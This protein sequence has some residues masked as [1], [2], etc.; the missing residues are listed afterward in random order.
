MF[1]YLWEKTA[2]PAVTITN[3]NTAMATFTAPP[4]TIAGATLV[5]ELTVTDNDGLTATDSVSI[6]VT[7]IAPPL[8]NP[9]AEAGNNQSV[10][11]GATVILDGSGSSDA[12]GTIA[13]YVWTQSSGSAVTI[14]DNDPATPS[15]SFTAPDVTTGGETLM[16]ELTVTDNNGLTASDS[17]SITVSDV[18]T[19]G[20]NPVADGGK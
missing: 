15:A 4:V 6:D 8:Q 7:N 19:P 17:V 3:A 1:A 13:T 20:Q 18:L 10:S 16:F 5:F 11:E 14:V 9:V 2:G 12:D